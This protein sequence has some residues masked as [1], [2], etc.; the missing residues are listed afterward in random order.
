MKLDALNKD[1]LAQISRN[2][3][4]Q[5]S[6]A[7]LPKTKIRGKIDAWFLGHVVEWDVYLVNGD[8]V[9]TTYDVG[10]VEGGNHERY[11]WIP[12]NQI[13]IDANI[14]YHDVVPIL[15]HE[16]IETHLMRCK[17]RGYGPAHSV[18]NTKELALRK[19]MPLDHN[20]QHSE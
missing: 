4:E 6:L 12:E 5:I 20:R 3:P 14:A 16:M 1:F 11:V 2:I 9:K 17:D 15:Y 13:W 8:Q 18:A 10:F 7:E 19:S